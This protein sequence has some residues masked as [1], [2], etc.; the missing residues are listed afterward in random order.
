MEYAYGFSGTNSRVNFLY[1][2]PGGIH[3]YLAQASY[4][5]F[6]QFVQQDGM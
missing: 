5:A 1:D 2:L 3:S 4:L 6:N